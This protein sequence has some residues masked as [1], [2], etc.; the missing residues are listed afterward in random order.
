MNFCLQGLL[1][2]MFKHDTLFVQ[3]WNVSFRF[4]VIN[5]L[6]SIN[7]LLEQLHY[8]YFKYVLQN[9]LAWTVDCTGTR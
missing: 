7:N 8:I 4:N 9:F 1:L 3:C 6:I 5:S 2:F